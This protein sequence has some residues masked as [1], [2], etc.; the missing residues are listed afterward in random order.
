MGGNQTKNKEDI[1]LNQ[2][3]K[4]EKKV[5]EVF[6]KEFGIPFNKKKIAVG[7]QNKEFDLVSGDGKIVV[8]VKSSKLG[9]NTTGKSGYDT[10]RK[11]RLIMAYWYLE[12]VKAEKRILVLT[13]KELFNQFKKD[14]DGMDQ[15]IEIRYVPIISTNRSKQ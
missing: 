15:K 13:N 8:E 12:K 4:A 5:K 14:M 11:A 3:I 2:G 6:E 1:M 10:T 7:K 9:N